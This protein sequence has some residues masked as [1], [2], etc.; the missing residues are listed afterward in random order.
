M[1]GQQGARDFVVRAAGA[2]RSFQKF[3]LGKFP[4]GPPDIKAP[5]ATWR[6]SERDCYVAKLDRYTPK[7]SHPEETSLQ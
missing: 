4:L 5:G 7:W 3:V 6:K 1:A 2:D